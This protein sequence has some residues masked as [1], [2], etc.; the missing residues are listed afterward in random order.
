WLGQALCIASAE[1]G[2]SADNGE[3]DIEHENVIANLLTQYGYTKIIKCYDPGATAKKIIDAF[4]GGISLANYTGHGS[5]TVWVTS[6][7]GTTH[8]KQLT[9]SNQLPFIFDVA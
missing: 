6:Y 8:V 2:P 9:N 5:E 4:N 3:S 7:F 1:G